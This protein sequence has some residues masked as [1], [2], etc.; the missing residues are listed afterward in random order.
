MDTITALIGIACIALALILYLMW[1][2]A[3]SKEWQAISSKA[4]PPKQQAKSLKEQ[5]I[6]LY[7]K[8]PPLPFIGRLASAVI[9]AFILA[10]LAGFLFLLFFYPIRSEISLQEEPLSPKTP[11]LL[12]PGEK[13][14]YEVSYEDQ[15]INISYEISSSPSCSGVVV[16]EQSQESRISYCFSKDGQLE[17]IAPASSSPAIHSILLYSPWMLSVDENF[18]WSSNFSLNAGSIKLDIPMRFEYASSDLVAGRKAYTVKVS[19][20]GSVPLVFQIDA[21]KRVPLFIYSDFSARLVQA[22]FELSWEQAP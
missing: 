9:Y 12:L 13:Y 11:L 16:T 10:Y 7:M 22:P 17:E 20:P 2:A 6:G 1:R 15:K 19:V 3:S 5:L 21:Q 8:I 18:S 4:I 14:V